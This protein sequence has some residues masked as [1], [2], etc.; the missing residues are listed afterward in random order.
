M[1]S[2]RRWPGILAFFLLAACGSGD[3]EFSIRQKGTAYPVE[4]A[5]A[6]GRI[7]EYRAGFST[8]YGFSVIFP[9]ARFNPTG[10]R[11]FV[12]F[13]GPTEIRPGMEY[14]LEGDDPP[15]PLG[16]EYHPAGGH[17]VTEGKILA[18]STR[19]AGG[20]LQVRFDRLEPRIGGRVKGVISRAVLV[21]YY[22][23]YDT[24]ERE[25][26]CRKMTLTIANFPFDTVFELSPFA[27]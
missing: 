5:P 16:L 23:G 3:G 4:L 19:R 15:H 11:G 10:Q 13:F 20:S 27:P 12:L 18:Y 7:R 24:A 6:R 22:E 2:G 9:L 14:A 17:R 8:D 26:P 25:E 21:G 1:S